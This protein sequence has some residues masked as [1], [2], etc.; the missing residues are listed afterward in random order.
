MPKI[1]PQK[2]LLDQ[3]KIANQRLLSATGDSTRAIIELG[4]HLND[5]KKEMK[6]RKSEAGANSSKKK[7]RG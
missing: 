4:Q 2:K 1:N 5:L 3:V 7:C 6:Y